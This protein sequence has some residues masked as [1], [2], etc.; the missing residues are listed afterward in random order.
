MGMSQDTDKLYLD[1]GHWG[2]GENPIILV[3]PKTDL[4]IKHNV[5]TGMITYLQGN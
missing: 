2:P 5:K 1:T 4:V 3:N